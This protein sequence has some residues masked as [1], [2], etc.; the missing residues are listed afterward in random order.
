[1]ATR[2]LTGFFAILALCASGLAA[3]A[4]SP[5]ASP[6][7]PTSS[8]DACIGDGPR[9]TCTCFCDGYAEFKQGAEEDDP[10]SS[11]AQGCNMRQLKDRYHDGWEAARRGEA[12]RCPYKR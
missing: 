1:M 4:Q 12:R 9:S 3:S 8:R 6:P 11:G 2:G 5:S 10:G 7:P